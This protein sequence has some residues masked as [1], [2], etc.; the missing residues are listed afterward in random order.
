MREQTKRGN[1][2]NFNFREFLKSQ[3]SA[4][5]ILIICTIVSLILANSPISASYMHLWEIPVGIRVGSWSMEHHIIEWVNDGLMAVFFFFVG[6]EIKREFV[7]GELSNLKVAILPV[8]VALGGMLVP[9]LFYTLVN[10]NGGHLKGFGIPMATDIAFA[11]GVLSLLGDRIPS[12]LKIFLMALAVIDDLGAIVVIALFYG[13]KLS[14]EY[15]LL[16]ISTFAALMLLNR[17]KVKLFV[18][19]L[20]LGLMLWYFM[21]HSGVHATIAGVLL[22]LAIPFDV[23]YTS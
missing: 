18:P 10:F 13:G 14:M 6:L 3:Q 17:L 7:S 8:L 5:I 4:G 16:C 12:N 11:L 22:A 20:V 23:Q 19:Y 21:L 2:P 1:R 15:T 9:G